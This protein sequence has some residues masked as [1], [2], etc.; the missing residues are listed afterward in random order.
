[1]A[2]QKFQLVFAFLLDTNWLRP[3]YKEKLFQIYF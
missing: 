1:M 2:I 3:V